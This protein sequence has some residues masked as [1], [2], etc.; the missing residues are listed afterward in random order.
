MSWP[1][2]L[3][4]RAARVAAEL[5]HHATEMVRDVLDLAALSPWGFTQWNP[6]DPEG[7]DVRSA[8]IGQLTVVYWVNRAAHRLSALDVVWS[9]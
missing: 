1:V 9:G 3:S 5:P 2:R 6:A 7:E 4:P 8:S